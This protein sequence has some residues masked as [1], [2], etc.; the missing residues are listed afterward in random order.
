MPDTTE[1]DV[2][3]K[4]LYFSPEFQALCRR[5]DIPYGHPPSSF[6]LEF[7]NHGVVKVTQE[8]PQDTRTRPPEQQSTVIGDTG[9]VDQH[10]PQK[11][12]RQ[13]GKLPKDNHEP[14]P[15]QQQTADEHHQKMGNQ[16]AKGDKH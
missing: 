8:I 6:K 9:P 5:F 15:R 12:Q 14:D 7:A 2:T 13:R 11:V 4:E 10:S 1:L 16:E 3:G